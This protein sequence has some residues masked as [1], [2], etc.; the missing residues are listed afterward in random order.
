METN[1]KIEDLKEKMN[2]A[3]LKFYKYFIFYSNIIK[4]LT[5]KN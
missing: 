4:G 5:T 1:K 2:L 3:M